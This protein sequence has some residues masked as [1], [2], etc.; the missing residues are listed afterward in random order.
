[1]LT[2]EVSGGNGVKKQQF[3]RWLGIVT[4]ISIIA[5]ALCLMGGCGYL[6]LS[7]GGFTRERVAAVF[8]VISLPVYLALGLAVPGVC[9]ELFQP[10]KRE[11]RRAPCH[12]TALSSGSRSAPA[13]RLALL[14][15]AVCLLVWG[16]V[17]G[18]AADVLTKA[19]NICTECIG[20]G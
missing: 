7:P 9:L 3:R 8:S 12:A 11:G 1:M 2:N 10:R 5:A 6:F 18:G 4:G 16:F 20:L 13:F 15:A 17:T 19:I 14:A